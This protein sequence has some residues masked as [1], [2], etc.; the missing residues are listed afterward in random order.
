LWDDPRYD[1][2]GSSSLRE[3]LFTTFLK[4]QDPN[5]SM[6]DVKNQD[7]HH[8]EESNDEVIHERRRQDRKER[9]VKEREDKIKAERGRVEA[10]IGRSREGIDKEGGEREFRCVFAITF[11]CALVYGAHYVSIRV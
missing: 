1:A 11:C 7:S 5:T 4:A 2:V 6:L 3:E 9:A 8:K 10:D